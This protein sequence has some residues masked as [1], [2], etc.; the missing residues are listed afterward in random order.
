MP[1]LVS[2]VLVIFGIVV[3]AGVAVRL[4]AGSF[5]SR[6]LMGSYILRAALAVGF[7][8][9]SAW[10]LP[11]LPSLHMEDGFWRIARDA[12]AYHWLSMVVAESMRWGTEYPL[13][14]YFGDPDFSIV[15]AGMY[16]ALGAHPLY[17]PLLNALCWTGVLTLTY[18][19]AE[20]LNGRRGA[21]AATTAVAAWP[22]AYIWSAQLM[23]DSLILLL[24][25]MLLTLIARTFQR[26][27]PL[28]G[29]LVRWLAFLPL[30][31]VMTRFRFYLVPLALAAAGVMVLRRIIWPGEGP[32]RTHVALRGLAM[33]GILMGVFV[34]AR[35]ISP[36][37]ILTSKDH[38]RH[39]FAKGEY[40]EARGDVTRARWE[41]LRASG[42][43]S[44]KS[45]PRLPPEAKAFHLPGKLPPEFRSTSLEEAKRLALDPVQETPPA[46]APIPEAVVLD[47]GLTQLGDTFTLRNT[48][49]MQRGFLPWRPTRPQDG[50]QPASV[51]ER[52]V[53]SALDIVVQAPAGVARALWSPFPWQWFAPAGDTG[54]FRRV[55]ALEAVLLMACTPFFALGVVRGLRSGRDCSLLL[56]VFALVSLVLMGVIVVNLGSLFRLRLLAV[57]PMLLLAG[58][59]VVY[60]WIPENK[61]VDAASARRIARSL[62]QRISA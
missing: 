19:L 61:N 40:F 59:Y 28:R 53:S 27:W 26:A 31:F 52:L 21:V 1:L 56:S 37:G 44:P 29:T 35:G 23:K 55:A 22:S 48:R 60:R 6:V 38:Q 51:V 7:Y 20:P 33:A 2:S 17:V 13:F 14:P 50:E 57:A 5:L 10:H 24:V 62:A 18:R 49:K 36:F 9:V 58:T 42:R 3:T 41:Y 47:Q 25:L 11:I 30:A 39:H 46:D 54:A 43:V 16:L 15:V 34:A 32:S 12:Q 4:D 8:V 45:P